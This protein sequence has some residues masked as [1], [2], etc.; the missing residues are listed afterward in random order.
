M[1]NSL[2]QHNSRFKTF[3]SLLEGLTHSLP[4]KKWYA[5]WVQGTCFQPLYRTVL[6]HTIVNGQEEGKRGKHENVGFPWLQYT[7]R[8]FYWWRRGYC[9]ANVWL[10]LP[11]QTARTM[12]QK[13][14]KNATIQVKESQRCVDKTAYS[15]C[16]LYF[17]CKT[18]RR[19]FSE[20]QR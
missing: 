12:K 10:M 3:T 17:W 14:K 6:I 19:C 8:N 15:N 16:K 20:P 18:F 9:S 5:S 1:I 2:M 7:P 11:V 13:E 4:I